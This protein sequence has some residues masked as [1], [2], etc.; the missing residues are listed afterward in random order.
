MG[1]FSS[2]IAMQLSETIALP[3]RGKKLIATQLHIALAKFADIK[4]DK[5]YRVF[6]VSAI[7]LRKP[8]LRMS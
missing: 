2:T 8:R 7:F 6:N 3:L 1:N 5:I 4:I